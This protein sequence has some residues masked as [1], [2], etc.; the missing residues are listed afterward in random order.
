MASNEANRE[1]KLIKMITKQ[2]DE[3]NNPIHIENQIPTQE[4]GFQEHL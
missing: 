4:L 2:K 3:Q 1:T